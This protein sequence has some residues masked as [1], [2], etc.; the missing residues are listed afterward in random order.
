MGEFLFGVE[1]SAPRTLQLKM[2]PMKPHT[3]D[4][5][6]DVSIENEEETVAAVEYPNEI[7]QYQSETMPL[8][9]NWKLWP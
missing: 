6:P 5:P 3:L 2:A 7:L 9:F 8:S 4:V 1:W